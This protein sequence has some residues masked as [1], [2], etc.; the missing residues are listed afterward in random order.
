MGQGR[1][2]GEGRGRVWVGPVGGAWPAQKPR[3]HPIE[4]A[5]VLH[6]VFVPVLVVV[7]DSMLLVHAAG[8][9]RMEALRWPPGKGTQG[10]WPHRW[11]HI[12]PPRPDHTPTRP[13]ASSTKVSVTSLGGVLPPESPCG[14]D[15]ISPPST[16]E[17]RVP[18]APPATLGP[19]SVTSGHQQASAHCPP[20]HCSR[21]SVGRMDTLQCSRTGCSLP[22]AGAGGG[23][24]EDQSPE[25]GSKRGWGAQGSPHPPSQSRSAHLSEWGTRA[26]M[27]AH[28]R[29]RTPGSHTLSA[30]P[31]AQVPPPWP[32]APSHGQAAVSP[33]RATEAGTRSQ[34]HIL[35]GQE[36]P[37]QA[38]L[39]SQGA[40]GL[41]TEHHRPPRGHTSVRR[42][43]PSGPGAAVSLRGRASGVTGRTGR[44]GALPL[45]PPGV[46]TRHPTSRAHS[47]GPRG[48]RATRTGP[49]GPGE[50]GPAPEPPCQHPLGFSGLTGAGPVPFPASAVLPATATGSYFLSEALPTQPLQ[51]HPE[52]TSFQGR[53]QHPPPGWELPGPGLLPHPETSAGKGEA[54]V[55]SGPALPAP[56]VTQPGQ[57]TEAGPGKENPAGGLAGDTALGL[58]WMLRL[59]LAGR[60]ITT[61]LWWGP[62]SG[63]LGPH[64]IP[65][66]TRRPLEGV[67]LH[68][69]FQGQ[70][71][72][73]GASRGQP[74]PP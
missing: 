65:P 55:G 35:L 57:G 29:R 70:C 10:K 66:R 62:R 4:A 7:D 69:W 12:H 1:G 60:G 50:G 52:T 13:G 30:H 56:K 51:H 21:G 5:Q 6:P 22:R 18:P 49:P 36:A 11:P 34:G 61:L 40:G 28:V 26:H 67:G 46:P 64:L 58:S 44:Q 74:G 45:S 20:C 38:A 8:L 59:A 53:L 42:T 43:H 15:P 17:P 73:R 2:Q 14:P 33:P 47:W 71:R 41:G 31:A 72:V 48:P 23:T 19:P 25:G 16:K 37:A 68:G 54:D 32:P 63:L 3:T 39:P 27:H 9:E 24:G